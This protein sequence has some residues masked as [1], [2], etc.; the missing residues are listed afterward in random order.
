MVTSDKAMR[1]DLLFLLRGKGAHVGFERA[2]AGMPTALRGKK[3]RGAPYTPWQQLEHMR[4]AQW[5]IL[6]YIRKPD[7]VSPRWPEEYWPRVA[8]SSADAWGKSVRRFLA[9]RRALE[10]LVADPATDLL[11]RVPHDPRGPTILHEVVLVAD[12]NAYH[13]GQLIVLRR[14]LGAWKE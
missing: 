10:R 11:A 14:L 5:D 9:D 12:H 7:H 6:E 1:E 4:I 13:L 8:P 3:P 2:V